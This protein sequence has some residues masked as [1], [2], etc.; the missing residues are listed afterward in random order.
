MI[1]QLVFAAGVG[2]LYP[3]LVSMTA[4]QNYRLKGIYFGFAVWLLF[5]SIARL[6][7]MPTLENIEWQSVVANSINSGIYGLIIA[8]V[9]H[10]LD[11][12]YDELHGD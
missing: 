11:R 5:Y 7:K 2:V 6:F 8:E 1:F 12:K 9:V 4:K 10:W 3:Y